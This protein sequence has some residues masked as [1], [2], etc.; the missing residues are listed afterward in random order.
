MLV[1]FDMVEGD[2]KL[3][4]SSPMMLRLLEKGAFTCL[5]R[6]DY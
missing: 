4:A 3:T 1:L 6:S 5:K 2:E